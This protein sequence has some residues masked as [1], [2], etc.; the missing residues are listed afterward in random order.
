MLTNDEK[1]RIEALLIQVKLVMQGHDLLDRMSVASSYLARCM[2]DMAMTEHGMEVA[3]VPIVMKEVLGIVESTLKKMVIS[4]I[5]GGV[6]T[7]AVGYED[8]ELKA[9]IDAFI[10]RRMRRDAQKEQATQRAA[11]GVTK[12]EADAPQSDVLSEHGSVAARPD[13]GGV[14]TAG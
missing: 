5:M 13:L 11:G 10:N 6:K 4:D 12:G 1:N 14:P 7:H 3:R 8:G 2:I 9:I